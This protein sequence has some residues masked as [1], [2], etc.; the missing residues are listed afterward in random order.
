MQTHRRL[1]GIGRAGDPRH[2]VLVFGVL[3]LFA[4]WWLQNVRELT[5]ERRER[6]RVEERAAMVAHLHD[7]VLQT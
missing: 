4:P 5:S 7:S 6:V 1:L 3:V 2:A